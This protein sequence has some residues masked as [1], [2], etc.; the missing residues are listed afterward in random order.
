MSLMGRM[1]NFIAV[2]VVFLTLPMASQMATSKSQPMPSVAVGPQYDSTHVY[3][4]PKDRAAFV[5]QF[6]GTFGGKSTK[7]VVATVT[8]SPSSTS[9][10]MLQTPAGTISLFAFSTPIP[11][12]FGSERTGF[13]VNDLDIAVASARS[14][15]AEVIVSPFSDPIGRDALIRFPGGM[16]TQLYWH[17]TA[18]HFA[19]LDT[20]PE[21]RVYISQDRAEEFLHSFLQFSHGT[22][23]SDEDAATGTEIGRPGYTFRRVEI[24]STFG[25]LLVLVTDGIT[26][27]PYGRETTGYEVHH[28]TETLH[29]ATSLGAKVLVSKVEVA[30]RMS[31]MVEFSGGYISEIHE[32]VALPA[33]R[34]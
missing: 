10:Q 28:L 22:V 2:C 29:K 3:V 11:A 27:Y 8:P 30:G 16:M 18:P 33:K 15:G 20:V 24:E 13:L 14:S 1:R 31:A 17:T 12:P 23:R 5:R 32:K 25:R 34:R 4:A 7:P 9:S 6:L 19:A 26:P 21:N